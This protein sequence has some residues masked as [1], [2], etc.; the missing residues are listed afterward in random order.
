MR[1]QYVNRIA[2]GNLLPMTSERLR[3]VS[4]FDDMVYRDLVATRVKLLFDNP[5]V[6]Q[7]LACMALI[8]ASDWC[9]TVATDG[10]SLFYNRH[11]IAGLSRPE[12]LALM[13]DFAVAAPSANNV[14]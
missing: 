9:E 4:I 10:R 3:D 1:F 11:F 6:G 8:E 2:S 5:P 14:G 12:L 7:L 13:T